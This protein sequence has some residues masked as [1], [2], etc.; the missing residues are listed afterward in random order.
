MLNLQLFPILNHYNKG[1]SRI[2]HKIAN[3]KIHHQPRSGNIL[4]SIIGSVDRN[5]TAY[6][7]IKEPARPSPLTLSTKYKVWK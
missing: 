7:S 5:L 1:Q 4:P 2:F 6:F 3:R